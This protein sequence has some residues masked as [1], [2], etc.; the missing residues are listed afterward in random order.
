MVYSFSFSLPDFRT[1]I[2]GKRTFNS[3]C[4]SLYVAMSP[5]FDCLIVDEGLVHSGDIDPLG[6]NQPASQR[7]I[8]FNRHSAF[9]VF[10]NWLTNWF[11]TIKAAT[12]LTLFVMMNMSNVLTFARLGKQSRQRRDADRVNCR[13]YSTTDDALHVWYCFADTSRSWTGANLAQLANGS[14]KYSLCMLRFP[15]SG[16]FIKRRILLYIFDRSF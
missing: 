16:L 1:V 11:R 3:F 2:L 10:A 14:G 4:P 5:H 12:A 9:Q 7:H 13:E 15:S 6:R 8:K